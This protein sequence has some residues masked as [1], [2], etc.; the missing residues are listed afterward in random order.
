MKNVMI[1][2]LIKYNVFYLGS[3]LFALVFLG[4][5]A[6]R[7]RLESGS[8]WSWSHPYLDSYI[9]AG[10]FLL[11]L[12]ISLISYVYAFY[13]T[14]QKTKIHGLLNKTRLIAFSWLISAPIVVWYSG[15]IWIDFMRLLTDRLFFN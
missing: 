9:I 2:S 12:A 15:T 7:G 13:K 6:H 1:P 5:I 11:I 4:A 10:L 8:G 3:L 14:Y